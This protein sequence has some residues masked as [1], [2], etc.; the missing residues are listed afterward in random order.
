MMMMMMMKVVVVVFVVSTITTLSSV[1]AMFVSSASSLTPPLSPPPVQVRIYIESLCSDCQRYMKKQIV[2]TMHALLYQTATAPWMVDPIM[3][4][5]LIVSG[6]AHYVD[7]HTTTSTTTASTNLRDPLPKQLV[8]QHGIGKFC[9]CARR[10]RYRSSSSKRDR[11]HSHSV[12]V[13]LQ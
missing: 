2:P 3:N 1:C 7:H 4:L 11:L 9:H 8:C 6:N 5:Q 10:R 12:F 13:F